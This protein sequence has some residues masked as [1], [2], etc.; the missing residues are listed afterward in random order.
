MVSVQPIAGFDV[1]PWTAG[2][3]SAG[4]IAASVH[5]VFLESLTAPETENPRARE[6]RRGADS[7]PPREAAGG[8]ADRTA[9]ATS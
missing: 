1:A 3:R 8:E 7:S 4:S 6:P 9:H 5:G 2:W